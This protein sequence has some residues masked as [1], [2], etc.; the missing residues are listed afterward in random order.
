MKINIYCNNCKKELYTRWSIELNQIN[1][2]IN[3]CKCIQHISLSQRIFN[4]W[5][6]K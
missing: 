4:F 6:K 2:F 1:I 3:P 5:S